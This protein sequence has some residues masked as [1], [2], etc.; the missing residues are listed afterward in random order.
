MVM[1]ET[2]FTS[3]PSSPSGD[4]TLNEGSNLTLFC[5]A[6]GKPT[7]NVT[8]TR[9]LK[10]GSDGDVVFFGNPWFIV[11]ISR[12]ATGTYRCTTYNGI[13]NP[14]S[15]LLYVNV[16]Y[17][18]KDVRL[19]TNTSRKVYAGVVVN[20]SCTAE[21]NPAV[22]T[23][24]LFENDIVI[25]NLGISGTWKK[26]M[27]N[28]GQFVFRCEANNSIQGIGKSGDTILTVDVPAS[29]EQV[30]NKVV[31]E[32]DNV[33]VYCNVTAGNPDPTVL[34]TNVA[35]GEHI[36]GNP[37]NI[38]NINR[39][40]AG[41]YRCTANNTCGVGSIVMD[42]DVQYRPKI[43]SEGY[44][45]DV[46][47]GD[48]AAIPCPVLGN[49]HPT[50]TWY[51]KNET[52]PSTM[53]NTNNILQFCETVLDDSGW[54]TCFAKNSLGNVTVMFQLRVE[55]SV[56]TTV[57]TLPKTTT[58]VSTQAV[59]N[60]ISA[61]ATIDKSCDERLDVEK[62]FPS[63]A[64]ERVRHL[65]CLYARAVDSR[66]GSVIVDFEMKFNQNAVVSEV[67]NVLNSPKGR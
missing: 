6:T 36:E 65:G 60:T 48:P 45:I 22:H 42:I 12:T 20:F 14:A 63:L 39:A 32:G 28:A 58:K 34:W 19:T 66:C 3:S 37:L 64:C 5:D 44:T 23:Y 47:E 62:R 31:K 25:K 9:V 57:T 46:S 52:S 30:K 56:Q 18:P 51:K 24:L 40:Q 8:W 29:V 35:T 54:Y 41:E 26:S 7:P 50:I 49:P 1:A 43:T 4:Q 13:G 2:S 61:T 67:L 17:Q 59:E 10:N 16:T 55:K 27:E 11:N 21:A 53:M 38:T 33:K 15:H